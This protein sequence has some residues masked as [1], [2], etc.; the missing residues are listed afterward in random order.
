MA[1]AQRRLLA[2]PEVGLRR[3]G[4]AGQFQQ[5]VKIAR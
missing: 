5:R 2:D 1:S 3:V 4:G